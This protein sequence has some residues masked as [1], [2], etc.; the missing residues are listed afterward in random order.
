[1]G[2]HVRLNKKSRLFKKGYLPGQ[3]EEVFVIRE[4]RLGP[5]P[6]YKVEE[7][8][9]TPLKGTFYEQD[10]QKLKVTDDDIFRMKKLSN[11]KALKSW[12]IG[13]AGLRN[14]TAGSRKFN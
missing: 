4:S 14:I 6:N 2:D 12:Y 8:D 9:G 10:L 3:T 13:K 11:L 5:V 1:M 7:W